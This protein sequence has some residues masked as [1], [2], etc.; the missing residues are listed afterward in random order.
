M[1]TCA[2]ISF[3]VSSVK[4]WSNHYYNM[5]WKKRAASNIY[6]SFSG[7]GFFIDCRTKNI[8][9][10]GCMKKKYSM[11]GKLDKEVIQKVHICNSNYAGSIG[12][13]EVTLVQTLLT[14]LFLQHDGRVFIEKIISDDDSIIRLH[15]SN[16][17]NGGKQQNNIPP[18]S[19]GADP[20]HRLKVMS[21]PIFA[22]ITTTKDPNTC[23][24]W[25]AIR[26]KRYTEYY[27]RQNRTK[28]LHILVY[29]VKVSVEHLSTITHGVMHNGVGRKM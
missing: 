13:M 26:I 25:D 28:H 12:M 24:K 10:F 8:I 11:C 29:N 21:K 9:S 17:T 6:N 5:G 18:P 3:F 27:I 2:M 16:I 1:H 7:H 4:Y 23:K 15:C 19:F 22:M 14:E 20:I